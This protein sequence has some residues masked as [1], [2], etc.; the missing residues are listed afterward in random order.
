MT[1]DTLRKAKA[2]A[3]QWREQQK[4]SE[5]AS[6]MATHFSRATPHQ[7]IEMWESGNNLHGRKLSP[8]E[9]AALMEQWI[10]IF[11]SLPPDDEALDELVHS[12]E[13]DASRVA[14]DLPPDDAIL[15]IKGAAML[16]G[17]SQSTVKRLVVSGSFPK[18]VRMSPR[19][20]GWLAGEVKAWVRALQEQRTRTRH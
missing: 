8:F 10:A 1:S 18:P 15:N 3:D 20:I 11:G 7:L 13:A 16:A 14:L 19:R 2:L 6:S 5:E 12:E 17:I 9:F 4:L